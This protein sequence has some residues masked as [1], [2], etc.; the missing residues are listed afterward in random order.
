MAG[1]LVGNMAMPFSFFLSSDDLESHKTS[2]NTHT[3]EGMDKSY[4]HRQLIQQVY[5]V[6]GYQETSLG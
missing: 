3:Q 6:F 2:S 1:P 4:T 5:V